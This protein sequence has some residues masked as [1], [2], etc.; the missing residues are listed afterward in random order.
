VSNIDR[1]NIVNNIKNQKIEKVIQELGLKR[2]NVHF[3]EN[4]SNLEQDNLIE[5]DYYALK[6]L[7]D[8][9]N[10]S[11]Q[12]LISYMNKGFNCGCV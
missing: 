2:S 8:I 12:F 1:N 7:C 10:L 9:L 4:Y 5:V 3:I 11:E 6:T